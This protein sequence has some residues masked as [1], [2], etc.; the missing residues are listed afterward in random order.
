VSVSETKC[1]TG[2]HAWRRV[3]GSALRLI[4]S[5]PGMP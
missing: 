2:P 4:R 1:E 3:S 5:S